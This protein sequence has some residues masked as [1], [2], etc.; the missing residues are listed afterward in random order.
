[1]DFNKTDESVYFPRKVIFFATCVPYTKNE[2]STPSFLLFLQVV[3]MTRFEL[4]TSGPPDRCAT[5]LRH[6]PIGVV[7]NVP[8]H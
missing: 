5:G 2:G 8:R 3:G 6:I 7:F 1:M 4:A